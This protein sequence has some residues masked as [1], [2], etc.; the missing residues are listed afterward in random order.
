M[1][2]IDIDE[3]VKVLKE[4]VELDRRIRQ[5]KTESDY[6]KFCERRCVAIE[7]I[8]AERE[9]DK[10]KIKELEEERELVGMPVRN[11]RDGRIGVVLHKWKGGSIA[12]LEK[13]NPR[14]INTHD[15]W[16]TLEIV[17]DKIK[18]IK[19]KDNSIPKQKVK[20]KIK[21]LEQENISKKELNQ[22]NTDLTTVYLKGYADAEEKYKQ[23]VKDR[24]EKYKK[25]QEEMTMK[26]HNT[27][28]INDCYK[29]GDEAQKAMYKR[30]ACEELLKEK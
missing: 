29:Y 21:E 18:Q 7:H 8:L 15:S 5:N 10:N 6:E 26:N 14:I 19:T 24:I 27:N 22:D 4:F 9:K 3:D 16:N 13:I 23:K 28:N 12:V 17:T 2:N 30:E 25:I 20:N 1:S 11:K